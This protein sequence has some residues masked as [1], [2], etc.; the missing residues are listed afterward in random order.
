MTLSRKPIGPSGHRSA[1]RCRLQS[2]SKGVSVQPVVK[3]HGY[4][5]IIGSS[6]DPQFGPVLLFGAGGPLVEYFRD[7]A[8]G[9]A[10]A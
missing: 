3:V 10:A 5:L 7:R 8:L 2:I 1:E 6:F 4:E 9:T